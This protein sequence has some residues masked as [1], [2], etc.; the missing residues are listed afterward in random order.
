M[1]VHLLSLLASQFTPAVIDRLGTEL[2]EQPDAIRKAADGAVP[3]LLGAL[4]RRVQA[5]GGASS[6]I[7]LLAGDAYRDA[8]FDVSQVLDSPDETRRAA[9]VSEPFL[10]EL[11]GDQLDRTNELLSIY[12]GTKPASSHTVLGLAASVLMGVLGRQ[13][14]EK[15]L[16]AHNLETMLLGQ[17]TEFRKALPSGLDA[18]GSILNFD[19]LQTPTGPQTEVQGADNFSGTIINPNIPKSPEGDRRMENV[20]WLRWAMVAMG[21]LVAA[22][23][24]QKCTQ[25]ES[26]TEGIST[27]STARVES[28]AVEDTSAAT[29]QS[30][31][32]ANGQ[33]ADST[34]SGALGMRD[35]S[36][37]ATKDTAMMPDVM[38]Q[39]ELPGGRKLTLGQRSF[40]NLLAQFIASKPK[41]PARTFTFDG[42]TFETSSAR[43]TTAS[44][45][46]VN[47]LIEIMKAY[48]DLRIRIEGHT[49]NMGNPDTNRE[50]SLSRANAV[51]SALSAAGI[52]DVR[53][54]TRGYG[55]TK[56]TA[57]NETE[58]GQQ[59]NR[60]IDVAIVNL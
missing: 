9:T 56:P 52:A 31:L 8:P 55:A 17:A 59:R 54:T 2:A 7:S 33:V 57:S 58:A 49:D 38:V 12:S 39:T 44:R 36:A 40:T 25:N 41:N 32:E 34:A 26:S 10:A 29:K 50:L 47:N 11:F 28:D 18:V 46:E 22:L 24:I 14:E 30:I 48:P 60:R 1:A 15:G 23:I 3:T 13:E 16:S 35:S 20:R 4:T 5:T 21:V 37:G 45:P 6:V 53:V 51:K 19:A 43:I 42:L 27:D